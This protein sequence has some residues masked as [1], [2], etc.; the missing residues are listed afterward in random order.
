MKVDSFNELDIE[1]FLSTYKAFKNSKFITIIWKVYNKNQLEEFLNINKDNTATHNCYAY[2]YGF[3]NQEYGYFNDK[4]PNGTSGDCLLSII[5]KK[6][7][8]NIVILVTRHF[9]GTKLGTGNLQK[10]YSAGAI[11]LIDKSSI[12]IK[13][14]MCKLK[15]QYSIND[16]KKINN[17]INKICVKTIPLIVYEGNF[18]ISTV[19]I[20]TKELLNEVMFKIKIL[21]EIIDY[22]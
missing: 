22:F 16:S 13:S 7:I 1:E 9:G 10:A 5:N 3:Q 20:K 12:K 4:E 15:I 2:K 18:V 8:T 17:F 19:L 21:E 11:E 14:I 6:N